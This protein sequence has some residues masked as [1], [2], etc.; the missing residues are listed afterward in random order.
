MRTLVTP[1]KE[2][3]LIRLD[4]ADLPAGESLELTSA[5]ET[6]IVVLGG[7]LDVA[8]DGQSLGRAGQRANV[9]EGPG[10]AVYAAPGSSV[11]LTGIG[12]RDGGG[13]GIAVATAPLADAP[14]GRTRIIRPPDQRSAAIGDGNWAR[15]VRTILGPEHDAGRLLIG[16]TVNPPGNWSSYPP[17]KHDVHDP[18]NE[19]QLEEVY[20]FKLDPAAGFGVQLLYGADGEEA[21]VVREGDVVAIKAGYHPVVAAPGYSLYYLW[22]MAGQGREMIPRLDPRHAWVQQ[23]R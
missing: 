22:V 3:D 9:F 19:V 10:D 4:I 16:E 1:G 21:F 20:F 11:R 6:L 8:I 13:A 5:D 7:V 17:H 23:G 12:D 15:Q 2:T 18:P 14:A